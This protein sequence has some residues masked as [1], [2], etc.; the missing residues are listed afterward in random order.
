MTDGWWRIKQYAPNTKTGFTV[1]DIPISPAGDQPTDTEP[2]W[3]LDQWAIRFVRS[4]RHVEIYPLTSIVHAEY[5]P[6]T[7]SNQ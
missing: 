7:E 1:T 2:R 6:P 4:N 3:E 5:Q